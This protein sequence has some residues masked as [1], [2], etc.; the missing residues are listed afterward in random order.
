MAPNDPPPHR[1]AANS[2]AAATA[3]TSAAAAVAAAAAAAAARA[4]ATLG[5]A[6]IDACNTLYQA[7]ITPVQA[8]KFWRRL[9]TLQQ[10]QSSSPVRHRHT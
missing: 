9:A 4:A 10:P 1:S 3:V 8:V 7:K 2:A 5:A 6:A